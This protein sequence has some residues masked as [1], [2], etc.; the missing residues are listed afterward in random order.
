MKSKDVIFIADFFRTD[1]LGGAESNDFVLISRLESEGFKVEKVKSTDVSSEFILKNKDKNFIVSNFIGLSKDSKDNLV[2]SG[3]KYIIYEHDH[4]YVSSRDPSIFANYDVPTNKIV[5]KRFYESAF[6]VVVLSKICKEV[7]EK[8][9]NLTNVHSI[10]CSLWTKEKFALLRDLAKNKKIDTVV[11]QSNNPTKGTSAAE[12]VCKS[13]NIEY[14]LISS[15]DEKEFLTMLSKAERLVFIPQVLETFCR[16]VAEAKMLGC[17]VLTKTSLLGF[18]SEECFSLSGEELIDELSGRVETAIGFFVKELQEESKDFPDSI[19][20]I[21]NCYRRPHLLKQQIKT[22]KNQT[23]QSD[24]I[25]VWV[26]DSEENKNYNFDELQGVKIFRCNHNWKFYGRFAA[27]MLA[28]TKYVAMFDDDTMPGKNW[29]KN[30]TSTMKSNPGILGGVGCLISGNKYYGH[31][32][33]GWSNPNE[34]IV[35]VDLVGHAWFF[36]R[37]CLQYLWREKPQTWDNGEDI[38]FSYLAQKYGNVKTFVP[39]HPKEDK[40]QFSSLQGFELGVDDVAT[41][42]SRNHE[43]FYKQRDDCVGNAVLNG[44]KPVRSR[45]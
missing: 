8:N 28:D 37:G 11:L 13:K 1:I 38:Q 33:V 12:N 22:I 31:Q 30:C 43:V 26:N 15:P 16:L 3:C 40:S 24:E 18:A 9:L 19:T 14:K 39:P 25:W 17:K 10:G 34:E 44:W 35:E 21:L 20:T 45:T 32:R 29:F 4:K 6:S 36:P 23:V 5:N 2:E 41:S 42:N 7:I 27:A